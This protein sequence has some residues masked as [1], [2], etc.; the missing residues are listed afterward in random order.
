[1]NDEYSRVAATLCWACTGRLAPMDC[2]HNLLVAAVAAHRIP[3]RFLARAAESG[4]R[5]PK[6]LLDEVR[7]VEQTQLAAADAVERDVAWLA[8][9]V[10]GHHAWDG[11]PFVV[12]KGNAASYLMPAEGTRR[13]T[14]DIDLLTCDPV[15]YEEILQSAGYRSR[16]DHF[17]GH[18]AANL[19][20]ADHCDVDLHRYCPS[21]RPPRGPY[22]RYMPD[23][24][25]LWMTDWVR[26]DPLGYDAIIDA[27]VPHPVVPNSWLR[28]PNV[29][30]SALIICLE[31]FRDY[32]SNNQEMA[33]IRLGDL[34]EVAELINSSDFDAA[35]FA[36]LVARCRAQDSVALA[37]QLIG[38]LFGSAGHFPIDTPGL[39]RYPQMIGIGQLFDT[40][41][42]LSDLL[43]RRDNFGEAL[44][45]MTP[46]EINPQNL[47]SVIQVRRTGVAVDGR[48]ATAVRS[49]P[50]AHAGDSDVRFDCTINL[51]DRRVAFDIGGLY[52]PGPFRDV[53][54]IIFE[55]DTIVTGYDGY[56]T[57][58]RYPAPTS[59]C[60]AV[61][62]IGVDDWRV[63]IEV[64]RTAFGLD[65]TA[66]PA[67][68][69]VVHCCRFLE[70]PNDSW[71]EYYRKGVSSVSVPVL[72]A[73]GQ[74]P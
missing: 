39:A 58:V 45:H 3:S 61:W 11:M 30:A 57:E 24:R 62:Q 54:K 16:G 14:A 70:P 68:P 35:V 26:C 72:L 18:E 71:D 33:T 55:H 6:R 74:R 36:D 47:P 51:D 23:R 28:V 10:T 64:P 22:S 15:R 65:R 43:L 5:I 69:V 50:P 1:M 44:R 46:N 67:V 7:S 66:M 4:T 37:G 9:V 41:P 21:W 12:L 31:L 60:S 27:S 52:P 34:C 53:V 59:N 2:P 8:E 29:T 32:V 13:G 73:A 20:S 17:G 19:Y 49:L 48:P 25:E 38:Q 42:R 63:R 40:G 56:R